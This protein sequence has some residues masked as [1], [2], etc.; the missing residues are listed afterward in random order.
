V[1]DR[2]TEV[3][4]VVKAEGRLVW[5]A[6]RAGALALVPGAVVAWALRG[7]GGAAA[8]A[9]ALGIVVANLGVSAIVLA[10]A[11]KRSPSNFPMIA[12]PSYVFRM[13]GV[14]AVMGVVYAN[15]GIDD[16]TFTVAFTTG[17]IGILTYECVLWARTPWLAIEFAKE[18]P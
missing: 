8:V 14:F 13:A 6:M 7:P 5:G 4:G 16:A 15:G 2:T 10:I 1:I 3:G 11:A 9:V 12:L 18:L 17:L